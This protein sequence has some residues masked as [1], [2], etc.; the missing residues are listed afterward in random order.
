MNKDAPKKKTSINIKTTKKVSS[1]NSVRKKV[2]AKKASPSK[3]SVRKKAVAKK[4]SSRKKITA[5]K[6][7]SSLSYQQRYQMISEAAY[8][9]AEKQNFMPENELNNWLEAEHQI[10]DWITANNIKLSTKP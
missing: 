3:K 7:T 9:I 8:H 2:A 5:K 10:N 6:Q 4:A 1:K